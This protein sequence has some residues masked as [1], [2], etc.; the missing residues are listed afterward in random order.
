M[1]PASGASP[2]AAT[3]SPPPARPAAPGARLGARGFSSRWGAAGGRVFVRFRGGLGGGGLGGEVGGGRGVGCVDLT[4]E[5]V[6]RKEQTSVASL[7]SWNE[8]GLRSVR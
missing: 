1:A 6:V 4:E 7:T 5:L 2:A 8:E 3:A